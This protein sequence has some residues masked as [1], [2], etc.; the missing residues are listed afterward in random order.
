M[1]T[2]PKSRPASAEGR[3][4]ANLLALFTLF[5]LSVIEV[6][7]AEGSFVEVWEVMVE[8]MCITNDIQC[9]YIVLHSNFN[10]AE[11]KERLL[12]LRAL[13]I[14]RSNYGCALE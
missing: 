11:P 6:S 5:T 12:Y 14:G 4:R 8:Y 10:C 3:R 2:R 7:E 9:I 1:F 13:R